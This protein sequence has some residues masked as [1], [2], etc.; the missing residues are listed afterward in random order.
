MKYAK[1]TEEREKSIL[2]NGY[3][4]GK[5][6]VVAGSITLKNVKSDY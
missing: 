1:G 5:G 3:S 6:P 2:D 4:T